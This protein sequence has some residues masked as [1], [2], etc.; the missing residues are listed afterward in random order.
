[1]TKRVPNQ[2]AR[3][4]TAIDAELKQI[5]PI[6]ESFQDGYFPSVRRGIE[7]KVQD[8]NQKREQLYRELD[9]LVPGS[10]Q[11]GGYTDEHPTD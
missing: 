7:A 8:L 3:E 5:Q 6:L 4:I 1:M 2:I 11:A 9:K 10:L